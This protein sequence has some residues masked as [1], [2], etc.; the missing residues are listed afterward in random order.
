MNY[1]SIICPTCESFFAT[2][3]SAICL[4][5]LLRVIFGSGLRRAR[6]F[7]RYIL[8]AVFVRNAL[9]AFVFTPAVLSSSNISSMIINAR[10][11]SG[12]KT[13]SQGS[14]LLS[15]P[16]P[17]TNMPCGFIAHK[18]DSVF[19]LHLNFHRFFSAHALTLSATNVQLTKIPWRGDSR[20]Y[21]HLLFYR[22]YCTRPSCHTAYNMNITSSNIELF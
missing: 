4:V 10:R 1:E 13:W 20:T 2:D 15:P 3:V 14:T 18:V 22:M 12:Q 9:N 6:T 21:H 8:Y 7:G 19:P 16:P 11:P 5:D 17:G